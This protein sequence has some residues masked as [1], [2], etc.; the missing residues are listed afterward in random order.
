MEL[1]NQIKL[2][3]FNALLQIFLGLGFLIF[4][5]K[6][7]LPWVV[8]MYTYYGSIRDKLKK[9][10]LEIESQKMPQNA[11]GSPF[12]LEEESDFLRLKVKRLHLIKNKLK[13]FKKKEINLIQASR[14]DFL[15]MGLVTFVLLLLAVIEE[16]IYTSFDKNE[17]AYYLMVFNLISLSFFIYRAFTFKLD[18][19]N[20][21]D[22]GYRIFSDK[23]SVQ[24]EEIGLRIVSFVSFLLIAVFVK[25]N[26]FGNLPLIEGQMLVV[27]FLI[28]INL[29]WPIVFLYRRGKVFDREVSSNFV[30]TTFQQEVMN[31]KPEDF[32][33]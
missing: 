17:F 27:F 24:F 11:E 4:A 3:E 7:S 12:S 1:F 18:A 8:D 10:R 5:A 6:K 2:S 21:V 14:I 15:Q 25:V 13:Q 32:I 30:F 23:G 16:A 33:P 29:L 19:A 9:F 26:Y 20:E 22:E 31:T 28:L